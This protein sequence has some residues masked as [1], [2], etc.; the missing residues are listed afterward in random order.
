MTLFEYFT[1][2]A[3]EGE[4]ALIVKQ[5]PTGGLYADGSPKYTWPAFLPKH[6]RKVDPRLFKHSYLYRFYLGH[7]MR[8]STG[9]SLEEEM[10]AEIE[11]GLARLRDLCRAD[12][13]RLQVLVLPLLGPSDDMPQE[14]RDGIPRRLGRIDAILEGLDIEHLDLSAA[15]QAA[16]AAGIDARESPAD[17]MHPS[18]G[19][20]IYFADAILAAGWFDG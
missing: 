15:H 18:A 3:P 12:G 4:T 17:P 14:W 20:A 8:Q 6:P 2:L 9:V 10:A 7:E 13:I 5:K 1:S 19:A 11:R 16:L